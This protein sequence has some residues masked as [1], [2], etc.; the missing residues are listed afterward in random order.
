MNVGC[1]GRLSDVAVFKN[2]DLYK[3]ITSK[4]IKLPK[5]RTLPKTGHPCWDKNDYPDI[6]YVIVGDDAF[7]LTDHMM[8]PY[9][10]RFL[11]DEQMCF[12]YGLSRFRRCSENVF[13]IL[14]SRFRIFLSRMNVRNLVSINKIIL[15]GV[16][17]HNMLCEKSRTSYLPPDYVDQEDPVT[18]SVSPGQW[19]DSVPSTFPESGP[20]VGCRG[21]RQEEKI[22]NTICDFVTGPGELL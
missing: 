9:K 1:Q 21:T 11:S 12:N 14:A 13:G 16:S 4:S 20:L 8:K 18:D 3:G 7:Q 15:A 22:R 10:G 5:P 19:R 6:P 2:T 17:L